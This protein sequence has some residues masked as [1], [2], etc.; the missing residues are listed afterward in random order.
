M[1]N[2]YFVLLVRIMIEGR[3]SYER[4]SQICFTD[5]KKNNASFM[6][7]EIVVLQLEP[8]NK[9]QWLYDIPANST[10]PQIHASTA[11]NSWQLGTAFG[12]FPIKD[13]LFLPFLCSQ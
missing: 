12:V 11:K 7:A 8:T 10:K 4:V 13:Y 2:N 9:K 6:Q 3:D 1:D 5:I